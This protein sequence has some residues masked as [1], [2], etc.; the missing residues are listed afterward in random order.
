MPRSEGGELHTVRAL[1]LI[2]IRIRITHH[3]GN[4]LGNVV[5]KSEPAGC[6]SIPCHGYSSQSSV[7]MGMTGV[8]RKVELCLLILISGIFKGLWASPHTKVGH[9]F[10]VVEGV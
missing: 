10:D 2:V 4:A 5:R 7:R 1:L 3:Q 9:A 8:V 6:G